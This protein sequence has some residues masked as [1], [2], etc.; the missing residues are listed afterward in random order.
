MHC[1]FVLNPQSKERT[2]RNLNC[3][4]FKKWILRIGP[5]LLDNILFIAEIELSQT[6][7]KKIE[8][9]YVKQYDMLFSELFYSNFGFFS[10]LK[11]R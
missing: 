3:C 1:H 11:N 4:F 9:L 8:A 2:L 7:N 5:I 10:E 6:V